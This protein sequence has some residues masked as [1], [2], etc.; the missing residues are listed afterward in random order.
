[1]NMGHIKDILNPIYRRNDSVL[2]DLVNY[3]YLYTHVC[4][5]PNFSGAWLPCITQLG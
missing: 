2:T 4:V 3:V 1:M 5:Y